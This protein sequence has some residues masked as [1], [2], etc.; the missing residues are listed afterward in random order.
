MSAL[1][2]TVTGNSSVSHPPERCTIRFSVKSNGPQQALVARN[3]TQAANSL[4][5]WFKQFLSSE[6]ASTTEEAPVTKFSISNIKSWVKRRDDE[7][8]PVT[9]PHH[10]AIT[11]TATFRDF[12]AMGKVVSGLLSYPD[13]EIK[14]VDW[15]LTDETGKRLSSDT[16]KMALRDAIQKSE[17]FSEVL[18]RNV[19]AVEVSDSGNS[20]SSH[21]IMRAFSTGGG[22]SS[23]PVK[24]DL[25]PQE[26]KVEIYLQV[27]FEGV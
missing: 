14:S 20:R 19:V 3:V 23:E 6:E 21:G 5:S 10:A 16:R 25:T 8:K 9:D 1:K 18:G 17:D 7:D 22:Y 2:I 12:S 26:I 27:T 13:V 11:F 15:S 24:L 4:Q